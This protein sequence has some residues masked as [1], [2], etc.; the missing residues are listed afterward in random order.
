MEPARTAFAE[1]IIP[2]DIALL[3]LRCRRIAPVGGAFGSPDAIAAFR[4]IESVTGSPAY[5]VVRDPLD[6]P[7]IDAALHDE[8]LHQMADFIV[9]KRGD[10]R[11]IQPET[12]SQSARHVIFAAAFP[13]LE[14]TCGTNPAAPGIQA[15]HDFSQRDA[16][17]HAFRLRSDIQYS[18][19][20]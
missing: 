12:F 11:S 15:Q 18:H 13:D 3:E 4:E 19:I 8:V 2:V 7:R 17:V 14:L 1:D 10:H 5:A 9:D 16:V 20:L 6:E